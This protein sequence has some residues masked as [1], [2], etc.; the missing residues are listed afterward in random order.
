[1]KKYFA[2][3]KYT[4]LLVLFVLAFGAGGWMMYKWTSK[5]KIQV[6][7]QSRIL[8]EKVKTVAKLVSVEGSF[9]EIYSYK[10]TYS[11]FGEFFSIISSSKKIIVRVE[12]KVSVGYDLE[13]MTFEADH[14][15]KTIYINNIPDP[16]IISLE[17]DL[18]Y[19]D[20]ANGYFN[21]FSEKELSKIDEKAKEAIRKKALES[22]LM[23]KAEEQGNQM[24][25]IIEFMVK[26]SGWKVQYGYADFEEDD[27]EDVIQE[28]EMD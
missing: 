13:K 14:A 18:D 11:P 28:L 12:A 5:P 27:L 2:V 24:L 15:S 8:L 6:E 10:D 16:E 21:S 9:S 22:D 4:L 23:L 19:Y 17:H 26:E 1:M 7:E 20:I 3:I 25:E